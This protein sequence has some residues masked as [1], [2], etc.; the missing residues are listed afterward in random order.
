MPKFKIEYRN[1]ENNEIETVIKVFEDT[2][3]ITNPNRVPPGTPTSM[4][5]LDWATDL[6]YSLS[7]KGWFQVTQLSATTGA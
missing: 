2:P 3:D 7:D 1:P 5:A 6:A 4:T